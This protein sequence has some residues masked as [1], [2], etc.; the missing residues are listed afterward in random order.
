MDIRSFF[1]PN[2]DWSFPEQRLPCLNSVVNFSA[3]VV[4]VQDNTTIVSLDNLTYLPLPGRLADDLPPIDFPQ[5]H[6]ADFV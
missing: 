5:T 4:A 6:V 3:K 2:S 1:N